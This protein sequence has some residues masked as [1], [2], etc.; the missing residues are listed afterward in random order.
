MS[1][2]IINLIGIV[3]I[4]TAKTAVISKAPIIISCSDIS[5]YL[6]IGIYIVSM[7]IL[8]PLHLVYMMKANI[9]TGTA[10]KT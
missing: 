5:V 4:V 6:K 3:S 7:F 9:I 2:S 1:D 8:G 10:K